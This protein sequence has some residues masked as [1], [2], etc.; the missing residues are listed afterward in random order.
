MMCL[1]CEIV[2]KNIPSK[3][4]QEDKDFLCFEDINQVAKIH[5]LIIPKQHIE[6]FEL[7]PSDVMAN[8]TNFI[9][10]LTK[11]LFINKTGYRLVTNIG[12]DGG[13]E[14]AHI[15]FHLLSG[16]KLKQIYKR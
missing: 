11:K 1:F 4:I 9:H 7:I 5:L 10:K 2:A 14:V 12:D 6:S 15:H 13:Q 16:E 8:M 3:I